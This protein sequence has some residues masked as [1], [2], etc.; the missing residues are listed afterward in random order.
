MMDYSTWT[1]EQ[2]NEE[3]TRIASERERLSA[4]HKAAR[5]EIDKRAA[6]AKY[7]DLP[8]AERAALEQ[9]ISAKSLVSAERVSDASVGA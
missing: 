8:K 6:L 5:F 4:A 3:E 7:A 9:M 1:I 2:L